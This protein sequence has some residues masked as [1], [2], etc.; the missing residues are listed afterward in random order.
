MLSGNLVSED[1]V[2]LL[3]LGMQAKVKLF[4]ERDT[5]RSL[6]DI[7]ESKRQFRVSLEA[8]EKQKRNEKLLFARAVNTLKRLHETESAGVRSDN[9]K[10]IEKLHE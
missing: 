6:R 4:I 10:I 3:F 9:A 8:L 5:Q 2:N 1:Q 7:E